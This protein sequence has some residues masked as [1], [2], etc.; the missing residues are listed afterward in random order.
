MTRLAWGRVAGFPHRFDATRTVRIPDPPAALQQI[1]VRFAL[2]PN[3]KQAVNTA[4]D[5]E[6]G[7][8][9][10]EVINAVTRAGNAPELPLEQRAQLQEVGGEILSLAE[11][12]HRWL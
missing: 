9:L 11:K 12:G 3:Q 1:A 7:N 2:N 10:F 8:T 4:F 6:P 5:V